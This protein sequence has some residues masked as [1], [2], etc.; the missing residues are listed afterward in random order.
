M[1]FRALLQVLRKV[2]C[3]YFILENVDLDDSPDSNLDIIIHALQTIGGGDGD[4]CHEPPR[5]FRVKC[6][7]LL[8]TDFGLPQRRSRLFFVGL[9]QST[10]STVS[11]NVIERLLTAFTMTHQKPDPC[12]CNMS[13]N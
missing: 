9:N 11:F 4:D 6:F 3:D 7:K 2:E 5:H 8:S 12:L 10:Q 1:T 13:I